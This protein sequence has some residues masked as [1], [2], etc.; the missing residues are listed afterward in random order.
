METQTHVL[1]I[2][3]HNGQASELKKVLDS[4]RVEKHHWHGFDLVPERPIV[5][6]KKGTVYAEI[7]SPDGD[8]NTIRE[9]YPSARILMNSTIECYCRM[10]LA[11]NKKRVPTCTK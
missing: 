5:V 2:G 10:I 6:T 7:K 9:M 4:H 11:R 1:I 3:T 8:I